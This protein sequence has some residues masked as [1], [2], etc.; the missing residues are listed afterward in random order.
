M[1]NKEIIFDTARADG[2]PSVL[3]ALMVTQSQFETANFTSNVFVSCSNGFGY[4]ATGTAPRCVL[5]PESDFYKKYATLRES[6]LEITAWIR[7]RQAEGIFPADLEAINTP[8][9]YAALLKKAGYYGSSEASYAAG[10]KRY[11]ENFK[12]PPGG[13]GLLLTVALLLLWINRK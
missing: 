9:I 1:D 12:V 10:M 2:M 4:K 3:A 7:R 11:L 8:E 13:A 6:T 5:S